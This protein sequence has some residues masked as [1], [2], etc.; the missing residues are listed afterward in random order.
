MRVSPVP[1]QDHCEDA[2][3]TWPGPCKDR[4]FYLYSLTNQVTPHTYLVLLQ[5]HNTSHLSCHLK[6]IALVKLFLHDK[7]TAHF[8]T[9]AAGLKL[10]N[11]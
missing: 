6:L 4:P 1:Y 8:G 3:G 11:V 2:V 7:Q 5:H 9:P 10:L